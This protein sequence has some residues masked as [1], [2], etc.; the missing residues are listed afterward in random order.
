MQNYPEC[1]ELSPGFFL[2]W[3]MFLNILQAKR[4]LKEQKVETDLLE[5]EEFKD[6]KKVSIS[7]PDRWQSKTL[8]LLTNVDQKSL[9]TEFSIVICRLT[10]D[11]WQSKHCFLRFL[12]CVSSIVESIFDS[13]LSGVI[14]L[15]TEIKG[16]YVQLLIDEQSV[17]QTH[18][19]NP[20][21]YIFLSS[22]QNHFHW[23]T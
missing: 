16:K 13:P 10:D 19:F 12:I 11:K 21:Y 17:S 15:C 23:A 14:S 18:L 4:L 1:K 9:K 6:E 3:L 5:G 2:T 8:I 7:T 22:P 20:I